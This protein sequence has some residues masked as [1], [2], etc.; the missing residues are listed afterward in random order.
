MSNKPI[1]IK[2][3]NINI[4]FP[5][6]FTHSPFVE[7]YMADLVFDK[8]DKDN[9]KAIEAGAKECAKRE[10]GAK[11]KYKI[12]VKCGDEKAERENDEGMKNYEYLA[13]FDYITAKSGFKPKVYDYMGKELKP[14]LDEEGNIA[15]KMVRS[16]DL[17]HAMVTPY[18]FENSMD[19]KAK[20][21][22]FHLKQ[23]MFLKKDKDWG[24]GGCEFDEQPEF[25]EFDDGS[26][27]PD[28]GDEGDIEF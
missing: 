27:A 28:Y 24:G 8:K 10:W 19:G 21:I 17:V 5:C 14:K 3:K 11:E 13:G 1:K 26:N 4:N 6:L 18:A 23:V 22:T 7:K 15:D 9:L 12:I 25:A 16:G 2:L 20:S